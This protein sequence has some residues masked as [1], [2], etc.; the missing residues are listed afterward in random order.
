ML[1]KIKQQLMKIQ[2]KTKQRKI[3]LSKINPAAFL[4]PVE[5]HS[6]MSAKIDNQINTRKS[7]YEKIWQDII[8]IKIY[9]QSRCLNSLEKDDRALK[10]LVKKV[11]TG[12][13]ENIEAQ[14]A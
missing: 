11:T 4:W 9:N 14:A 12:D 13:R 3:L 10:A 8:Q 2:H 1:S 6:L 7:F 5:T